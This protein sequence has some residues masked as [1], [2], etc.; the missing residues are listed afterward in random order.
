MTGIESILKNETSYAPNETELRIDAVNDKI[1][2][3]NT[4]NDAVLL[5]EESISNARLQRDNILYN[6][7][8]ALTKVAAGVKIY[9]KSVFK[10]KSPEFKQISGIPFRIYKKD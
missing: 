9:T 8:D 6:N 10:A 7:P 1:E 5:I 3:L 4:T 2:R